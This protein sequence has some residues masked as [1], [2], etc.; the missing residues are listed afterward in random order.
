MGH[1]IAAE[2][3]RHLRP[4]VG[5]QEETMRKIL[6]MIPAGETYD[7]DCVRWYQ[8]HDVQRSIEHYHNIGDAFVHD[9][10]LKLLDYDRVDP[11][12][13]RS[14]D[15]A[16]IARANAEYD[17]CFL[18]GSNYLHAQM[19]WQAT[20]E[21]LTKLQDPRARV[22]GRCAGAGTWSAGAVARKRS[23]LAPDCA[24]AA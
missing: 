17:Y 5:S 4:A 8:A 9:S 10:S 7:H 14:V 23:G 1:R 3:R 13:I 24:T 11:I 19:N 6:V 22:R 16:A 2:A 21:V 20:A 15:E 12:E 18:R